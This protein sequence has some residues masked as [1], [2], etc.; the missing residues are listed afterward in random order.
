MHYEKKEQ[1][2]KKETWRKPVVT[3]VKLNPEQ[4][5]LSCCDNTSKGATYSVYNYQCHS[6]APPGGCDG[7][8]KGLCN[9]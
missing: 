6:W 2:K 1:K 4:A 8:G 9:S 7:G 5:V 3:R